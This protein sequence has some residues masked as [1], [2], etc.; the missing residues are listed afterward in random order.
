MARRKRQTNTFNLSFLDIMS[1]GFGAVVLVFLIIDHSIEIQIQS[2]NAEVLSEVDLLEEDIRDGEEGLVRLRNAISSTDLDIVDAQ[3]RARIA[4][5]DLE[6]L[7]QL[8][9]SIESPDTEN[10]SKLRT[11]IK[12]LEAEIEDLEIK[13]AQEGGVSARDFQG[14]GYRQYITGLKLGGKRIAILLDISASML[15]KIPANIV[16]FKVRPERIRRQAPKWRQ[17]VASAEW[18]LS[19]LPSDSKF[20]IILFN[21]SAKLV[22]DQEDPS[23]REAT[24]DEFMNQ[25]IFEISGVTPEKGTS[26]FNAFSKIKELPEAPDNIFLIT[27]GL[28]TIGASPSNQSKVSSADRRKF[29]NQAKKQIPKG[30]PVNVILLPMRGDPDAAFEFWKL[31]AGT[32]GAL[33][34]PAEDWP[35]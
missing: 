17:A 19:Q 13:A 6:R 30:V 31:V 21:E 22:V 28:P 29:M 26:F 3:G 10:P 24:D 20:Q 35:K 34:A 8:I 33:M 16:R 27:D 23:W 11:D 1:C 25:A 7:S 15:D 14:D 9:K 12:K 4:Q 18:V 5:D 2:V 32:G